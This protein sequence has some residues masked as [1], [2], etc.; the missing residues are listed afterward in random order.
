VNEVLN[1]NNKSVSECT[2]EAYV[3]NGSVL[4]LRAIN[5]MVSKIT[6]ELTDVSVNVNGATE[7]VRVSSSKLPSETFEQVAIN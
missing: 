2:F 4:T 1:Y 3:S 7:C 5:T 6:A